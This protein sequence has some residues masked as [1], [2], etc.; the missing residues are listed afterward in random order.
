MINE[1][2]YSEAKKQTFP[3]CFEAELMLSKGYMYIII[4]PDLVTLIGI[5]FH[6]VIK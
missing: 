2:R 5:G 1:Q 4:Y 6:A 3:F